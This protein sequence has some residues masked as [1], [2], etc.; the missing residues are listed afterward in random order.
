[1]LHHQVGD[2]EVGFDLRRLRQSLLDGEGG[3][4]GIS[5]SL[6]EEALPLQEIGIVIDYQ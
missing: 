4:N 2:D 5:V 6:Q 1:M 3:M